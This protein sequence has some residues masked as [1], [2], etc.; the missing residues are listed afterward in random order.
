MRTLPHSYEYERIADIK[1][2]RFIADSLQELPASSQVLDVGCGNGVISRYLGQ[3]GYNVLGIDVSAKTIETANARNQLPN[4]RFETISAEALTA[5]GQ[6]YDA[7]ICSEVLEHLQEP[8]QLL[9]T[10]YTSLKDQGILIVTVPNGQ[11]P[12][13]LCVTRPM[14]KARNNKV[15]W[16]MICQAKRLLGFRGT[17]VQSAA[18]NLDHVQFFTRRDLRALAQRSQFCIV[19]FAK[20]NFV[21]DVFPFSLLTKRLRFLQAWDC[22]VAEWLPYGCTGGFH[23]IWRKTKAL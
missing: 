12:R 23:T 21:E 19:R 6:R 9:R 16:P 2:L 17:T 4:V 7:V 8:E 5:Q 22:L 10:L 11:G 18:D 1:R 14:L 3:L 13:E 15:L 20:S